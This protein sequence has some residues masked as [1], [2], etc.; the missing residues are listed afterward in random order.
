[1]EE[2][3]L[4][5]L[6][7]INTIQSELAFGKT[8]EEIFSNLSNKTPAN[9][10]KFAYCLASIPRR[11]LRT[12]YLKQNGT[13]FIFLLLLAGLS[14]ASELPLDPQQSTLFI[15]I[16]VSVPLIFAYFVYQFHGGVYR[17]L[18]IWCIIDL[19]ES[20]VLLRFTTAMDLS[21]VVVLGSII[22]IT[23]YIARKVFPN[24][25]ILGPKQDSQGRY[26]L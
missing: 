15:A 20:L 14:L 7:I 2:E 24:L 6:G 3:D 10:G 13:L 9:S 1:M 5:L 21:R 25:R 22:I 12:K 18:G 4:G 26:L 19:V 11:L 23:F 16:K 8:R 17:L